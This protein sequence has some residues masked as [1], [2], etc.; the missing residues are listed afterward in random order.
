VFTRGRF[1]L[2][3][4]VGANKGQFLSEA[5]RAGY[6]GPAIAF[7]PLG[8]HQPEIEKWGNVQVVNAAVGATEGVMELNA[9]A[10]TEFSSAFALNDRYTDHYHAPKIVERRQ[11]KKVSLDRS[12]IEGR[13][14]FLKVDT[15]GNDADVLRGASDVLERVD[16][17]FV[18]VPFLQ[19]YDGGCSAADLFS[20]AQ[21]N[22]F[23][24]SRVFPNSITSY[25]AI[26]DGDVAF[27]KIP[28][29]QS[30]AS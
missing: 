2:L 23:A 17:L 13:R 4:D 10:E 28:P 30:S 26:V 21:Q 22:G 16:L 27:V 3:V 6:G 15:Q 24:P 11:V 1:D 5:R 12:G 20:I 8:E 14:I 9:Y 19:I 18:E 25:G 29:A 7:E